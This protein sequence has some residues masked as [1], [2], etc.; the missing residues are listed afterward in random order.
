M[1][2]ATIQ[3]TVIAG[4]SCFWTTNGLINYVFDI[5]AAPFSKT[6]PAPRAPLVTPAV[7]LGY[8]WCGTGCTTLR[9]MCT[10]MVLKTCRHCFKWILQKK[11]IE[12][13]FNNDNKKKSGW[14][15]F[16]ADPAGPSVQSVP[17]WAR[18][19]SP[20][21]IYYNDHSN[22]QR[23]GPCSAWTRRLMGTEKETATGK[24]IH[25]E[26]EKGRMKFGQRKV[27]DTRIE[28]NGIWLVLRAFDILAVDASNK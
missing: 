13:H 19:P 3:W 16:S 26:K 12:L 20:N 21:Q 23:N 5:S 8:W 17:A 25:I 10:N 28:A 11:K 1:V 18:Q 4:A 15:L 24:D 6:R 14:F 2:T 27:G 9:E 7:S 22:G